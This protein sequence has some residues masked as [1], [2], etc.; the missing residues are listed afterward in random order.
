MSSPPS[1]K[2]PSVSK[3]HYFSSRPLLPMPDATSGH[4]QIAEYLRQLADLNYEPKMMIYQT[5]WDLA[6][7]LDPH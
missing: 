2:T 1:T 5:L 4:R 7:S 3:G 6:D